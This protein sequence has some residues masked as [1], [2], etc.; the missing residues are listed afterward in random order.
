MIAPLIGRAVDPMATIEAGLSLPNP[1][2]QL[3]SRN[4]ASVYVERLRWHR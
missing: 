3:I 1:R 2:L 4:L